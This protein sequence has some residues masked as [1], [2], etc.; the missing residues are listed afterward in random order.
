MVDRYL[1]FFMLER[2]SI[3]RRKIRRRVRLGGKRGV[4]LRFGGHGF[5]LVRRAVQ[6]AV[7]H[8]S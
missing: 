8:V 2:D 1:A 3:T 5:I 6:I 7:L 4:G